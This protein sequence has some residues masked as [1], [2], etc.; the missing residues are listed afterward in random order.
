MTS[1]RRALACRAARRECVRWRSMRQPRRIGLR[2]LRSS[3]KPTLAMPSVR[4]GARCRFAG[5]QRRWRRAVTRRGVRS[6][7]MAVRAAGRIP[8]ERTNRAPIAQARPPVVHQAPLAVIRSTISRPAPKGV[9][10]GRARAAGVVVVAMVGAVQGR[11]RRTD[12]MT[13]QAALPESRLSRLNRV[14]LA[15]SPRPVN[16]ERVGQPGRA[17]RRV[18]RVRLTPDPGQPAR[19]CAAPASGRAGKAGKAGRVVRQARGPGAAS[20]MAVRAR[21]RAPRPTQDGRPA[22]RVRGVA[23]SRCSSQ[24]SRSLSMRSRRWSAPSRWPPMRCPRA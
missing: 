8:V 6:A 2:R 19:G 5:R 3:V 17:P 10:P 9:D 16:P 22:A 15:M 18:D 21:R 1:R 11:V 14:S 13:R 20:P 24:P 7:V 12:P 4:R 23:P